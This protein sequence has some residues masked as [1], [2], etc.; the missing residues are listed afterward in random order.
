MK[1]KPDTAIAVNTQVKR[2]TSIGHNEAYMRTNTVVRLFSQRPRCLRCSKTRGKVRKA[3]SMAEA[4]G[5]VGWRDCGV[6]GPSVF[7]LLLIQLSEARR[8]GS[9][10]RAIGSR[11]CRG[12]HW[13]RAK[14]GLC[15]NGSKEKPRKGSNLKRSKLEKVTGQGGRNDGPPRA[16]GCGPQGPKKNQDRTK[17]DPG[18]PAKRMRAPTVRF[19][20]ILCSVRIGRSSETLISVAKKKLPPRVHRASQ[21]F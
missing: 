6:S 5:Q 7:L 1:K 21:S 16:Q 14:N 2:G 9:L 8:T 19:P 3:P 12:G 20:M 18:K 15:Q 17:K 4:S 13:K 10:H 11:S